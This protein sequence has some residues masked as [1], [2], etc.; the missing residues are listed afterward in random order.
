[1]V[2]EI[3]SEVE[4]V[5]E[6]HIQYHIRK[7]DNIWLW[8]D[9]WHEEDK[10]LSLYP[11]G[12]QQLGMPLN[13][14]LS[15]VISNGDWVWR[16]SRVT[17]RMDILNSVSVIHQGTDDWISRKKTRNG[18]YTSSSAREVKFV[19]PANSWQIGTRRAS[20]KLRGKHWINVANRILLAVIVYLIWQERKERIFSNKTSSSNSISFQAV[21]ITKNRLVF[22]APKESLQTVA[23]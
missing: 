4:K 12:S 6:P 23:L 13:S 7:G 15:L 18:I 1:M 9:P 11:Q 19:W 8:T 10:L 14:K 16:S 22:L 17:A 5:I 2:L 21:Q 3:E 20:G